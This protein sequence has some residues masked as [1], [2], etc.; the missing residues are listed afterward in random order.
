MAGLERPAP[1]S[2][3]CLLHEA[4]R[5]Q[6]IRHAGSSVGDRVTASIGVAQAG[7]GETGEKFVARVD[8]ATYAAKNAGRNRTCAAEAADAADRAPAPG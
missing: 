5:T 2:Q 8:R 7:P 6:A 4:L 3:S 1:G